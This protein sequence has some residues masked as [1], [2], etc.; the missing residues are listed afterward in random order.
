MEGWWATGRAPESPC[1]GSPGHPR[2]THKPVL[3]LARMSDYGPEVKLGAKVLA[4]RD[5]HL[6]PISATTPEAFYEL[7]AAAV[8][9]AIDLP[10]LLERVTRAEQELEIVRQALRRADIEAEKA[11]HKAMIDEEASGESTFASILRESST[12]T[13]PVRTQNPH[14]RPSPREPDHRHA[15]GKRPRSSMLPP[16]F[17]RSEHSEQTRAQPPPPP[18]QTPSRSRRSKRGSRKIR[19][20]HFHSLSWPKLLL[21]KRPLR[22]AAT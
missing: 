9:D 17:E 21:L 1:A 14:P 7:M 20:N 12:N 11:R 15:G 3:H 4:E 16:P 5:R 8:L 2:S 22:R 19:A 13:G 10:A 6:M 18:S